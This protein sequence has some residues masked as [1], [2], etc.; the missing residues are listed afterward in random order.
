MYVKISYLIISIVVHWSGDD[1][2]PTRITQLAKH[3]VSFSWSCLPIHKDCAIISIKDILN[4]IFSNRVVD[5]QLIGRW[6]KHTIECVDDIWL[7]EDGMLI[8]KH[9]EVLCWIVFFKF[10]KGT[11]SSKNSNI[12]GILSHRKTCAWWV[13]AFGYRG[14][15]SLFS[16]AVGIEES[17]DLFGIHFF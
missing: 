11:E 13:E 17:R 6:W 14:L 1:T 2:L 4:G 3:C 15:S 12:S 7:Q 10:V 16:R 9:A 8:G 5:S